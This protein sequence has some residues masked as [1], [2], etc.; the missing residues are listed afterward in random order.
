MTP[1]R[2]PLASTALYFVRSMSDALFSCLTRT[3]EAPSPLKYLGVGG[4]RDSGWRCA[5]SPRPPPR[6]LYTPTT[7]LTPAWCWWR[8]PASRS[9]CVSV[10]VEA[11]GGGGVGDRRG[12]HALAAACPRARP[13]RPRSHRSLL[14]PKKYIQLLPLSS[15]P[16]SSGPT[17]FHASALLSG[18]LS[19]YVQVLQQGR[20]GGGW[21]V[22]G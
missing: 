3:A 1:A 22:G 9:G 11:G 5:H 2:A 16:C 12:A 21:W 17:C 10:G 8:G 20:E 6:R 7:L 18:L 13:Q 4:G 14:G 15:L 19:A